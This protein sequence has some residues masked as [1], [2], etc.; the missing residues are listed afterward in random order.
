MA[1]LLVSRSRPFGSWQTGQANAPGPQD[2]CLALSDIGVNRV[3]YRRLPHEM[4]RFTALALDNI[5]HDPLA[6]AAASAHRALR[7]FIIAGSQDTRTAYQFSRAGLIYAAGRAASSIYLMLFVAGL[8]I[9]LVRRLHVALMLL[10]IV[11]VPLTI[12][13]MLINARYS[14]TT[15]PFMFAFV[16]VTLVHASDW[17]AGRVAR[18]RQS[19]AAGRRLPAAESAAVRESQ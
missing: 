8:I 11:F 7:V 16:A 9:A 4:R 18:F 6:Y 3:P 15:Q 13:F 12:C 10:P 1:A 19:R 5:R 14:M 17:W 2:G